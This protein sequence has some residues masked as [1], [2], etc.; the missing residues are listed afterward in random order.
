MYRQTDTHRHTQTQ[1]HTHADRH[2]GHDQLGCYGDDA[3]VWCIK[4]QPCCKQSRKRLSSNVSGALCTIQRMYANKIT[5]KH[6]Q[7]RTQRLR[8]MALVQAHY[9]DDNRF[10]RVCKRNKEHALKN[11][12]K[13]STPIKKNTCEELFGSGRTH[14]LL[15]FSIHRHMHAHRHTD[16]R[17][18][19][20][21][22]TQ[23]MSAQHHTLQSPMES[24]KCLSWQLLWKSQT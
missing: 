10:V 15:P 1:T 22:L 24:R 21:P 17:H 16:T 14:P 19:H 8:H 20:I 13:Q 11:T 2:S 6:K 9:L 4:T 23:Q 5:S 3:K 18:R 7:P 12:Q